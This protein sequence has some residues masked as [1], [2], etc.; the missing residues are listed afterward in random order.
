[1]TRK[2]STKLRPCTVARDGARRKRREQPDEDLVD[3]VLAGPAQPEAGQGHAD[4]GYGKQTAGIG[5]EVECG[6][7][8]GIAFLRQLAQTRMA[9]GKQ[10]DF[11]PGKE[12]VDGDEQENDEESQRA[13]QSQA[14]K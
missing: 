14:P 8:A 1:M 7:R 12:S 3:G 11:G 2:E 10:R 9:D 4:L 13:N 5:Q 6:L